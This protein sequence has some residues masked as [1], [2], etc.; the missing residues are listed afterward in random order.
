MD[1]ALLP[2]AT[3][4]LSDFE[5]LGSDSGLIVEV[6]RSLGLPAASFA[7]DLGCG[8]GAN[9]IALASRLG[10]QVLGIELHTPF[11]EHC[12]RAAESAGVS[13][14]CTLRAGDIVKL[15]GN[16]EPVDLA[17]LAAL[18][19]T[20]GP[21]D[22][23]MGVLR[24]YVKPGGFIVISDAF[25]REDGCTEFPGF[26][27]YAGIEETRKR[28]TAWGDEIVRQVIEPDCDSD[29]DDEEAASICG[30]AAQIAQRHPQMESELTRFAERQASA[31]QYVEKNLMG[32]VWA[33]KLRR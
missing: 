23:T 30:R 12:V 29:D 15:A 13:E 22:E 9:A 26:E 6:V 16:I 11:L 8:K 33:V 10:F 17:L 24:K 27:G 18:G 31:Y 28:L 14:R 1:A 32:A 20:L 21:L 4:L 5:E 2:Y 19:D 7:V 25:L 3:E